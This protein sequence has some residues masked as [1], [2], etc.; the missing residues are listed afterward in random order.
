MSA[1]I[2]GLTP[3]QIYDCQKSELRDAIKRVLS[4]EFPLDFDVQSIARM[5]H[6]L[7][8]TST[9]FNDDHVGTCAASL[10]YPLRATQDANEIKG[11]CAQMLDVLDRDLNDSAK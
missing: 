10:Q 6:N 8:G 3:Q 11:L 1:G 9:Y 7:S 4:K 2:A 5:M